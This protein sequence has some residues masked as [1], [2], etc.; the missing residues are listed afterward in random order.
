VLKGQIDISARLIWIFEKFGWV[1]NVRW[2]NVERLT[3]KRS[4]PNGR[5]LG[6]MARPSGTPA[7]DRTA[8]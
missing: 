7:V 2:P 5:P 8:A 1:Y 6:A 3:A 4:G